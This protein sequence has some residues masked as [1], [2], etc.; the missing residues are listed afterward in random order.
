M[1]LYLCNTSTS[2]EKIT[3]N[4]CMAGDNSQSR[5]T[6]VKDLTIEPGETFE[7]GYEKL[8][9]DPGEKIL[10]SSQDGGKVNATVTYIEIG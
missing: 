9:I 5:N 2:D 6:I 10:V 3:I 4:L 7:F 8:I 1:G